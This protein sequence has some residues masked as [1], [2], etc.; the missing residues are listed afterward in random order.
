MGKGATTTQRARARQGTGRIS[1]WLPALLY[2]AGAA[3]W[4]IFFRHGQLTFEAC[5][6][7][8]EAL[9]LRALGHA[10]RT[11]EV[12]WFLRVPEALSS[13]PQ[14]TLAKDASGTAYVP[15][16]ALPEL[17]TSPQIVLLRWLGPGVFELVNVL[18][19]YSVGFA[20]TMAL[21]ARH[22]LSA[23]P[24]C[25]LFLLFNFNGH[26]VSHLAVGHAMWSGY[27]LL[28]YFVHYALEWAAQ[29]SAPT[30][31]IRL[32]FVLAALAYQG[33]IHLFVSAA[34]VIACAMGCSR[35]LRSGGAS[36][37]GLGL[38][39][40]G[41]RLLPALL[42]MRLMPSSAFRGGYA[43]LSDVAAS[44]ISIRGPEFPAAPG[45]FGSLGWWEYDAYIGELGLL[46]LA[47]FG[48]W[49]AW[50]RHRSGD[51]PFASL[52]LPLALV[53]LLSLS[54][55]AYPL[56]ALKIPLIASELRH[57]V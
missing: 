8:K 6:W 23:L 10:L 53:A 55:V 15:L 19:L 29:P 48:V 46:F 31:P 21:R 13:F 57:V 14:L 11:L 17:N 3:H 22:G 9:Y 54:V 52:L 27:F 24:F 16:L 18:L 42:I 7:P 32:A 25:A 26:I 36:A 20:G 34:L 49:R 4:V 5:D 47:Y 56:Y 37:L 41:V 51:S 44:M 30:P 1:W 50:Q 38:G 28:P 39:L 33:S 40:S 2:L 43:T 45:S 12:P 35:A